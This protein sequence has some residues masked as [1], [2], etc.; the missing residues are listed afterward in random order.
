VNA[1]DFGRS[2]GIN[3][4][5]AAAHEG[6]VVT[7]ASL[8]VRWPAARDAALYARAHP[9]LGLG[10]HVDL[11]EWVY[12]P[13]GWRRLYEVVDPDD[14][15][16]VREEVWRQVE[17]FDALYGAYPTHLDSHQH[18]HRSEPARS[19]LVDVGRE[20]DVIVR[21]EDERVGHCGGFHGHDGRGTRIDG[22]ITTA[23][24]VGIVTA[25]PPGTTEVSCHP[26]RRDESGSVYGDERDCE[27]DVLCD[28][29]VR[30]A[31]DAEGIELVSFRPF[32]LGRAG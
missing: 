7:S 17:R 14:P 5:V 31:I 32:L 30:V 27:V 10:L 8:M 20:L 9:A 15:G 18:V 25:I 4:G 13:G 1:D 24:L 21:G 22:A 3:R 26:A 11:A 6:G 23:A 12:E 16:A 2:H 29:A 19:A 28:P